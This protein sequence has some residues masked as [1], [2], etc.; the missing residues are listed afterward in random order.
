VFELK[1]SI[2]HSTRAN[3]MSVAAISKAVRDDVVQAAVAQQLL[4]AP[5]EIG[6]KPLAF[7]YDLDAWETNLKNMREAFPSHWL[8]A[9][10]VK[11]NPLL[12]I[13]KLAVGLGHGAECASIGEL[14]HSLNAGFAAG[15]II[16]DSPC[17]TVPEIKFA[18]EQGVHLNIDNIEEL[19][20]IVELLA[21]DES[22]KQK[23]CAHFIS[24]YSLCSLTR[25]VTCR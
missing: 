19:E 13:Q 17:K 3:Q 18:L 2:D 25:D 9:L 6:D 5:K 21:A 12:S 7:F 24:P 14:V 11:T 22:L 10:A 1:V 15:D 4:P 20:R 16:F 23:V 8:H